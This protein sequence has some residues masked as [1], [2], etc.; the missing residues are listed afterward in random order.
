MKQRNIRI[1]KLTLA[2]LLVLTASQSIAGNARK[3]LRQGNNALKAE[4][5]MRHWT[6]TAKLP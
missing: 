4:N 3:L 6:L 1:I 5:M 2:M